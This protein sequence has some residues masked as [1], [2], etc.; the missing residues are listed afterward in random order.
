M[1]DGLFENAPYH[2]ELKLESAAA[3]ADF[4]PEASID[5]SGNVTVT[6][7]TADGNEATSTIELAK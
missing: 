3:A 4:T 7:P 6:Y 2:T 1:V 5:A